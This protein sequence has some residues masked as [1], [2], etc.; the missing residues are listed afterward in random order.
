MPAV[1]R[2]HT[3]KVLMQAGMEV[4]VDYWRDNPY[5]AVTQVAGYNAFTDLKP[6]RAIGSLY[7][8]INGAYKDRET[9]PHS[10]ANG[11]IKGVYRNSGPAA[12]VPQPFKSSHRPKPER[13]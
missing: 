7:G 2:E 1:Q 6:W 13:E 5:D 8:F 3:T 11:P 10:H 9:S 12:V 4:P